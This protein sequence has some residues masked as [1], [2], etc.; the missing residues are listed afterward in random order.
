MISIQAQISS[1]GILLFQSLGRKKDQKESYR[2]AS[3]FYIAIPPMEEEFSTV[4]TT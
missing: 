2:F 4:D 1:R 3:S